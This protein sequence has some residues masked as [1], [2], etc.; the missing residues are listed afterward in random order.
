VN[1]L[2]G[3]IEDL[4][5]H[6]ASI[7]HRSFAIT[8]EFVEYE[9]PEYTVEDG[10]RVRVNIPDYVRGDVIWVITC[11]EDPKACSFVRRLTETEIAEAG[12][13]DLADKFGVGAL[14]ESIKREVARQAPKAWAKV[15]ELDIGE[16]G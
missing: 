3:K 15:G 12:R 4:R 8:T 5:W 13:Y 16:E 9:P 14:I 1:S 2:A 6:V 7:G 10:I 11:C